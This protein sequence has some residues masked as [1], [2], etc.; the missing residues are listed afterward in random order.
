MG[1]HPQLDLANFQRSSH[2]CMSLKFSNCILLCNFSIGKVLSIHWKRAPRQLIVG[3]ENRDILLWPFFLPLCNPASVST[4]ISQQPFFFYILCTSSNR[5]PSIP[6]IS[7][8][9]PPIA[10]VWQNIITELFWPTVDVHDIRRP[11]RFLDFYPIW[12][13]QKPQAPSHLIVMLTMANIWKAH[14]RLVFNE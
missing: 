14:Y 7:F 8:C 10:L 11:L 3:I 13:S 1:P 12:Y 2:P 4:L 6:L 9:S 5:M